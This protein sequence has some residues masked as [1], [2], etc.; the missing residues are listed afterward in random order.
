MNTSGVLVAAKDRSTASLA[1]AQ[2]REK[3]VSKAYLALALGVPQQQQFAVDGPIAAHPRV[4]VARRV[5]E[6]GLDAITHVKVG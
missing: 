6:G 1:H 4:K 5:A 2:F 3:T